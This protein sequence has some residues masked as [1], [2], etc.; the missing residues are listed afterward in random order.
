M[1]E[2]KWVIHFGDFFPEVV[3]AKCQESFTDKQ[4][5][6]STLEGEEEIEQTA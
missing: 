2:G 6:S 4:H 5:L 1:S 3:W